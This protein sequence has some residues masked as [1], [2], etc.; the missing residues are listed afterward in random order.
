MGVVVVPQ[1]FIY[2]NSSQALVCWP[3]LH[4]WEATQILFNGHQN[5][6]VKARKMGTLR[7]MTR[8][9]IIKPR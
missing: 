9:G 2:K 3:L 5:D 1:N 4:G 6:G 8:C 7:K